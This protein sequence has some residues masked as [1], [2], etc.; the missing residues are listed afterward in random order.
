M[1]TFLQVT[2]PS[3]T[4][5]QYVPGLRFGEPRVMALLSA[6]VSFRH[7]VAGFTN[8]QLVELAGVLLG[9]D[10]HSRQA[11]Y[12]LRRLRRKGLIVRRPHTQRYDLTPTSRTSPFFSPRPTAACSLP[13]SPPWTPCSPMTSPPAAHSRWRGVSYNGPSTSSSTT[14]LR[15]RE[16]RPKVDRFL[17]IGSA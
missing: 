13:A 6:L 9:E 1:A 14:A 12:D 10:Y 4:E 2:R 5:G 15:P 17:N 7:L 8:R 16:T 3:I 11:T